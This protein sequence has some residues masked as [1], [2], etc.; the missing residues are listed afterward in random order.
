MTERLL[1]QNMVLGS[2]KDKQIIQDPQESLCPRCDDEHELIKYKGFLSITIRI[3]DSALFFYSRSI[4]R[5]CPVI[6]KLKE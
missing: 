3:N 1:V 5:V 6:T 2:H 4:K